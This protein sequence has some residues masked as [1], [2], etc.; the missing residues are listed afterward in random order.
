MKVN[1]DNPVV[2]GGSS[3]S[4]FGRQHSRKNLSSP[5]NNSVIYSMKR[6]A[7]NL[8]SIVSRAIKPNPSKENVEKSRKQLIISN[9]R[10]N[11]ETMRQI[12]LECVYDFNPPPYTKEDLTIDDRFCEYLGMMSPDELMKLDII[13][14]HSVAIEQLLHIYGDDFNAM[15]NFKKQK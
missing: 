11:T 14:A 3:R 12:L 2:Y 5:N 7:K 13:C 4:A 15:Y 10:E 1:P 9:F 8:T 6:G